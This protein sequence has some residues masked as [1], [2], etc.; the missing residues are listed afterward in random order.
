MAWAAIIHTCIKVFSGP[1]LLAWH[2]SSRSFYPSV[3]RGTAKDNIIT[4]HYV[5]KKDWFTLQPCMWRMAMAGLVYAFVASACGDD[6]TSEQQNGS[7]EIA[8]ENVTLSVSELALNVGETAQLTAVVSPEEA[9]GKTVYWTSDAESVATVSGGGVVTALAEGQAVV[10][11]EAGGQSASCMVTVAA[12]SG[13]GTIEVEGEEA[14]VNLDAFADTQALA[15]AIAAADAAGVKSYVLKGDFSKLGI[16]MPE[17]TRAGGSGTTNPFAGTNVERINMVGITGWPVIGIYVPE[18]DSTYTLE[19]LPGFAFEDDDETKYPKLEEVVM[20]AGAK[21]I[22]YRAFYGC[23]NLYTIEMPGVE[24]IGIEAFQDCKKLSKACFPEV[25]V[26][27]EDAFFNCYELVEVDMPKAEILREDALNS[28]L[29][30]EKVNLPSAWYI[31]DHL[32]SYDFCYEY[33]YAVE[34]KTMDLTLPAATCIAGNAFY[35]CERLVRLSLPQ[36]VSLGNFVFHN[37][38]MLTLLELTSSEDI[39]TGDGTFDD[40]DT[41]RCNLVLNSNKRDETSGNVWRG[42]V[43][44]SISFI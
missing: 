21:A 39:F 26:V 3:F 27:D 1:Q 43:W 33:N 8:V 28:C 17:D 15:E 35:D 9:T 32:F 36:A 18:T 19:G 14:S 31:G 24:Y 11:A 40:F 29:I 23:S 7:L 37:C 16:G 12:A 10:T 41:T 44:G 22:G 38:Y 42:V 2:R 30:M 20:P 6:E 5:M 25:R 4:I 13:D 34:G